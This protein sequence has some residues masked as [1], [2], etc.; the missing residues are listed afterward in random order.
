MGN[1]K[2]IN[3][4]IDE[5]EWDKLPENISCSR[6]EW[7][8]EMIKKQNQMVDEVDEIDFKIQ[9]IE[10]QEKA[11]SVDKDNLIKQRNS[12]LKQRDINEENTILKED[13]MS[14]IRKIYHNPERELDYIEL[15]RVKRI[16]SNKTLNVDV[17]LTQMEK[18]GI[19]VKDA[20][21]VKEKLKGY[22]TGKYVPY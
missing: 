9:A 16:A 3:I 10:N 6:S 14:L 12:I 1:K 19:P 2:R 7:I 21:I 22:N 15:D 13:A 20:P 5:D 8:N 18:E 4:Y 11:L 17:L